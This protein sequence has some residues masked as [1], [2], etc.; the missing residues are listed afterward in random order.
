MTEAE[1]LA[2]T[3]PT[4]MLKFLRGKAS[5]RKLRL[6]AVACCRH[7][8]HLLVDERSRRGVEEAER[9]AEGL[10]K[11]SRLSA[12]W[13]ESYGVY[14]WKRRSDRIAAAAAATY[15][16]WIWG[17]DAAQVAA[18]RVVEVV[19]LCDTITDP[20]TTRHVQSLVL[21]DIFGNPFRPITLDPAWLTP[22]VFALAR[23]IYAKRAFDRLPILADALQDA[24]CED[25]DTL[26]HCRGPGP[27]ARGCWV[28]DLVLGKK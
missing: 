8:W 28:V 3:N 7:I 27:H 12:A 15:S 21:A 26:G 10:T 1:W 16:A 19:R 23:G 5:D 9:Y 6:F 22:T 4:L 24:G 14:C 17:D 2:A 20:R 11:R 13:N 25:A 18:D